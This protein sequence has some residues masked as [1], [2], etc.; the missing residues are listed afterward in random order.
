MNNK[1]NGTL[2]NMEP[3]KQITNTFTM[4]T[5]QPQPEPVTK[6]WHTTG[7]LVSMRGDT[8]GRILSAINAF[9]RTDS[10]DLGLF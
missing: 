3:T 8:P 6:D 2:D 4:A 1:D 10:R 9:C 7:T 5:Q